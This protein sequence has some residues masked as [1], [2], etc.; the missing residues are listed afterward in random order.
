[1]E[2]SRCKAFLAA[3]ECGSLTR[4]AEKLNYTASGVSQLIS[5]MESDFGFLLLKR[6]TRGVVLTAEGEKMLPAVR[7]F[8]SQENRMHELAANINGL[9]IGLINIA[10]YSSIA[11]HWLPK[12]IAEFKKKYPNI[13][14]NLMEGVRQEVLKWIEEGRADI[15]LLSGG[16]DIDYD[17]IPL[18]DDPMIAVLPKDH[19]LADAEEFPL[20]RCEQEEFIMPAMG[21]DEDV[22]KMLS[23]Y[24]IV[25]NIVYSTNESFSAWALIENGLG[26]SITNELLMHG[27][28]C[29]VAKIP[30][31]PPEKITLGMILPSVKHASPAVKRFVK[32]AVSELKQL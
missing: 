4:A 8:L 13:N 25:P 10:A 3:A 17:W 30:V 31:S 14:I 9:D 5:A 26:I 2:S 32:Y 19:P 24:D 22:M 29:D 15:G 28:N 18:A 23:K 1:M 16:D 12:V 11:T 27:W 20:D 7:A 6:T 21:K